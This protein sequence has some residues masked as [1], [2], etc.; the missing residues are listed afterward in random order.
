MLLYCITLD[1]QDLLFSNKNLIITFD[2]AEDLNRN[3]TQVIRVVVAN[4]YS[5][6]LLPAMTF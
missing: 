6:L 5:R 2:K 1:K 3:R 4:C